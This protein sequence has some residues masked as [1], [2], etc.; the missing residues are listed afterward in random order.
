MGNE[1]TSHKSTILDKMANGKD[2]SGEYTG[3]KNRWNRPDED[4]CIRKAKIQWKRKK[5]QLKIIKI[6][7]HLERLNLFQKRD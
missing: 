7:T 3:D 4:I 1:F 5:N 2:K 6:E